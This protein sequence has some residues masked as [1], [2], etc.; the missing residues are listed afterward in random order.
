MKTSR[1][2][3]TS[4]VPVLQQAHVSEFHRVQIRKLPYLT[5]RRGHGVAHSATHRAKPTEVPGFRENV[6]FENVRRDDLEG[7]T[8]KIRRVGQPR[9]F[10]PARG[11]ASSGRHRGGF[12]DVMRARAS[13]SRS[14]GVLVFSVKIISEGSERIGIRDA[15]DLVASRARMHRAFSPRF[16]SDPARRR[17]YTGKRTQEPG[18]TPRPPEIPGSIPAKVRS[19]EAGWKIFPDEIRGDHEAPDVHVSGAVAS[20]FGPANGTRRRARHATRTDAAGR[21][22]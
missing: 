19:T 20:E 18:S 3:K 12:P 17:F 4:R 15:T 7:K 6:R 13:L 1:N 21:R 2:Q 16:L 5:P 22:V 11:T 10:A 8:R 9:T 14:P